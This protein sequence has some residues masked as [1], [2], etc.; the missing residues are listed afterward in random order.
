MSLEFKLDLGIENTESKVVGLYDTATHFGSGNFKVYATP[1]M[2]A[3]MEFTANES[4]SILSEKYNLD[5]VGIEINVKHIKAT[6]VKE[7]VTC[8]SKLVKIE[9][10]VLEFDI[11]VFDEHD[12]IGEAKH[13]R[14]VVDEERFMAKL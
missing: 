8:H 14:Y 10:R 5:T 6:P 1:A 4:M 2:I 11:E 9:G 7:R 13:K 12:K 3:L